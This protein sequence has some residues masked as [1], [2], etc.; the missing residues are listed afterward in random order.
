MGNVDK[1]KSM[2]GIDVVGWVLD[3]VSILFTYAYMLTI[4]GNIS[5]EHEC[6]DP[7]LLFTDSL[8]RTP[9]WFGIFLT[10][11]GLLVKGH[12]FLLKF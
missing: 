12:I 4:S 10:S 7:H 2:P 6:S 11:N 3:I 8:H 5:F 1:L 9:G